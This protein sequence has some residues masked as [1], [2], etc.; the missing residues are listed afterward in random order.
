MQNA[1]SKCRGLLVLCAVALTGCAAMSQ[2]ECQ[3]GDWHTVGFNDGA[4]GV[5]VTRLGDYAQACSKYGV[6]P[7]LTSYRSGYDQGLETYCRDGNG[8]AVGSSGGAYNGVCP[9][10][11]EPQF[12][13]GFRA[14]RQLFEMQASVN[15]LQ[16]QIA[17]GEQSLRETAEQIAAAEAAVISDST[18]SDQRAALLLRI[19]ELSQRQGALRSEIDELQRNLAVRQTDLARYRESLAY[20][21]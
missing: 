18:P 9:A 10:S 14:G 3:L 5:P 1:V 6:S 17:A 11:L 16:G 13:Q 21:H 20:N 12:M 7:D 19:A 4:R 2:K 8:F 15:D